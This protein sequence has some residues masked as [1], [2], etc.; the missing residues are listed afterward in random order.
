MNWISADI[1]P[2]ANR[3][4]PQYSYD[5]I[6]HDGKKKYEGYYSILGQCFHAYD[7]T[8]LLPVVKYKYKDLPVLKKV[9][10]SVMRFISHG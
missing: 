7:K 8:L 3:S 5:L 4:N 2:M 9:K 1:E 6:L 10:R